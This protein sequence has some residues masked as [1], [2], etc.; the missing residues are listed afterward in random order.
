MLL[1]S[2]TNHK[3]LQL[4]GLKSEQT[5]QDT[6]VIEPEAPVLRDVASLIYFRKR[7]IY[8][9]EKKNIQ[10]IFASP[11]PMAIHNIFKAVT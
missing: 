6:S 9:K 3:N 1:Q 7:R 4:A 5:K 8:L 10:N 11:P 2:T